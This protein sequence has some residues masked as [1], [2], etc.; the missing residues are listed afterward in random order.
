MIINNKNQSAVF[1][2]K[3]GYSPN[4]TKRNLTSAWLK[5]ARNPACPAAT[6]HLAICLDALLKFR[7]P[8]GR[9]TGILKGHEDEVRQDAYLLLIQKYLAGNPELMAATAAGDSQLIAAEIERSLGSSIRSVSKSLKKQMLRHQEIHTYGVDLDSYETNSCLHPAYR[10]KLWQ[11]P[12]D[13]Q[14]KLVFAALRHAVR[15]NLLQPGNAQAAKDML[16]KGLTKSQLAKSLGISRQ[17]VHQRLA[18]VSEFLKKH[19]ETQEFPL[20]E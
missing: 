4:I 15:E 19:I 2:K 1:Q 3:A 9:Y 10:E 16:G 11:L 14:R 8:R 5:Y 18:S 17:A 7:L 13:L 20:A 6:D 12:F